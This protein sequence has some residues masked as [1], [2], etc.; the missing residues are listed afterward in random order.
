MNNKHKTAGISHVVLLL[1]LVSL[2]NDVSSEIIMAILPV[3]I[4]S[5]GGTSIGIGAIG[6]LEECMKSFLSYVTG[7]LSDKM[8]RR[9]IFVFSGY[10]IASAAKLLL[11]LSTHWIMVLALRLIDRSGKAIRSP[12][13]DAMIAQVSTK[14]NIGY[15]F[16]IHRAMDT[17]GA[18]VGSLLA[19]LMF[20]YFNFT[21]KHM[22]FLGAIIAFVS[23]LPLL[24]I[25][26]DKNGTNIHHKDL[27]L[28]NLPKNVWLALAPI[29]IYYLANFTYM[30]FLLKVNNNFK[31]KLAIGMPIFMYLIFN[32]SYAAFSAPA[33]YFSDRFGRKQ[34]ISIG[35]LVFSFTCAGLAAFNSTTWFVILFFTYGLAYALVEGNLR[36]YISELS[37]ESTYGSM[38][39]ILYMINGV[40]SLFASLIAG[41]LWTI[42]PAI[43]F[44]YAS[45]L[46]FTAALLFRLLH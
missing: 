25:K 10:G 27:S 6:G 28:S 7:R 18:V 19:L 43:P 39:G 5:I 21:L 46:A 30:F 15:S 13:R 17:S 45:I 24:W 8:K 23:L 36:A 4:M 29:F 20:W 11:A 16:G 38:L 37:T 14:A 33:G 35:Y 22:I 12:A 1:G 44:I 42:D 31:D 34:L 3:F 26:E 32:L 41:F 9:L 40:A 2:L